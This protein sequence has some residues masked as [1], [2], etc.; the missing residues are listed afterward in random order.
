LLAPLLL[1]LFPLN[2]RLFA[3][4]DCQITNCNENKEKEERNDGNVLFY[5][6][7]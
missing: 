2:V 3:H 7:C 1:E 4:K 5:I 6:R